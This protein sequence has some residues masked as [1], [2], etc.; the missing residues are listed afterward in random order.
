MRWIAT[1]LLW[2]ACTA[3]T[4]PADSDAL[5]RAVAAELDAWTTADVPTIHGARIALPERVQEFYA[6]RGFR[7]A[8][9]NGR[10]AEQ[11]HRALADSDAEGLD[12]RDYHLPLLEE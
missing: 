3:Q 1:V 7:A 8:W 9:N 12:P 10:N 4:A 2:V 6:R 5:A 11:L